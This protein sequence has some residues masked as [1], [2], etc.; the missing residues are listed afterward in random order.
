MTPNLRPGQ[1][2]HETKKAQ[3]SLP[4]SGVLRQKFQEDQ[5]KV[6][7]RVNLF[8]GE[9]IEPLVKMLPQDLYEED[10]AQTLCEKFHL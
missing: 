5:R 2:E 10:V 6:E 9:S 4:Q 3:Q 1:K 7:R 8:S